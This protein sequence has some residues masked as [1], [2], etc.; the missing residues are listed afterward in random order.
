MPCH[1]LADEAAVIYIQLVWPIG[2]QIQHFGTNENSTG[3]VS[4]ASSPRDPAS[5]FARR[6]PDSVAMPPAGTQGLNGLNGQNGFASRKWRKLRAQRADPPVEHRPATDARRMH[7]IVAEHILRVMKSAYLLQSP[8]EI[9]VFRL[10]YVAISADSVCVRS[11]HQERLNEVQLAGWHPDRI[12]S[13]GL[14]QPCDHTSWAT[15]LVHVPCRAGHGNG[16]GNCGAKWFP[17][18]HAIVSNH[19]RAGS[20]SVQSANPEISEAGK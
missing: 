14:L 7:P 5:N 10:I 13:A 20:I 17:A 2:W 1:S 8:V 18:G 9:S 16:L 6:D 12:S 3:F 11:P 15:L 19:R 4:S